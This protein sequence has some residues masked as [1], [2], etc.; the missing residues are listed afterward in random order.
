M[1][2]TNE[3]VTKNNLTALMITHN[4]TDALKYGNRL[5]VLN[6]GQIVLDV[7]GKEKDKLTQEK[8]LKYFVVK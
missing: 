4:L 7:N 5:I 2:A 1:L 8:I 6:D 3:Q